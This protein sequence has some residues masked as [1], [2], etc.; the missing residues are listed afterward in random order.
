MDVN[1]S[2]LV[3]SLFVI[4]SMSAGATHAQQSHD[5][6]TL[7]GYI[8]PPSPELLGS[9][10]V[11]D[12]F[13]TMSGM[14]DV[15]TNPPVFEFEGLIPGAN[16]DA[17]TSLDGGGAVAFSDLWTLPQPWDGN[18][19]GFLASVVQYMATKYHETAHRDFWDFYEDAWVGNPS[20][21]SAY[22]SCMRSSADAHALNRFACAEEYAY[23]KEAER[24]CASFYTVLE[25]PDLDAPTRQKL[26]KE[27]CLAQTTARS[28]CYDNHDACQVLVGDCGPGPMPPDHNGCPQG[29]CGDCL[30]I[31]AS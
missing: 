19:D 25:D 12:D 5:W 6:G 8:K 28:R 29:Y 30:A 2:Q 27:I 11:Y 13:A 3:R 1:L 24:L 26:L 4:V 31:L 9:L 23:A 20:G 14:I 16:F 17:I 7:G 18:T 10:S 15:P 22:E 21:K